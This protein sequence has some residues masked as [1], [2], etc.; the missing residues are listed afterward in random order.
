MMR[1]MKEKLKNLSSKKLKNKKSSILS[2]SDHYTFMFELIRRLKIK[3]KELV[4]T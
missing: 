4:N 2:V 3:M 1:Q